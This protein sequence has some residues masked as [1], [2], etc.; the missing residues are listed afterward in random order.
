[1]NEGEHGFRKSK[2][3]STGL[4]EIVEH[5]QEALDGRNSVRLTCCGKSKSTSTGLMEIV[6]H[7]QEALDG[8]NS[9]RFAAISPKFDGACSLM[10][11]ILCLLPSHQSI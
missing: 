9:V 6:E 5:V 11:G 10:V 8:R 4:M 7:V 3:T 1:M 2:S